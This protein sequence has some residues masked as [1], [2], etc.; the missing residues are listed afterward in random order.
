MQGVRQQDAADRLGWKL[1]TVSGRVCKAKQLLSAAITRRG[2]IGPAVLAAALGGAATPLAAGL[3]N[4]GTVVAVRLSEVPTIIHELARGAMGGVMSKV[5]L[6]AATVVVVGLGIGVGTNVLSTAGAQSSPPPP[7]GSGGG[8][9]AAPKGGTTPGYPGA[10]PGSGGGFP[11]GIGGPPGAGAPG[12]PGMPGGGGN[13]FPGGGGFGTG[14]AAGMVGSIGP[15]VEY[16]FVAKPKNADAFKKLLNQHGSDGWEYV[17]VIPDGDELIFKR[18]QRMAGFSG[19]GGMGGGMGMGPMMGGGGGFGSGPG[20][21]RIGGSATPPGAAG[22]G[23]PPGL[24]GPGGPPPGLPGRPGTG[25]GGDGGGGAGGAVFPTGQSVQLKVGETIRHKMSGGMRIDRI[26]N[27]DSKIA[28]VNLDPT[29][30]KRV[31][32]KGIGSGTGTLDLTDGDGAFEVHQ[33]RVK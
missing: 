25:G 26:F 22:P 32:I 14:G 20:M 6:L 30:S 16:Q 28:E 11:G 31:L 3:A 18:H 9:G 13:S 7:G 4:K 1:G 10:P 27:H 21:P 8:P 19:M 29:D 12:I 24:I 15:K 5:K 33:I 17:G 23:T 2:L